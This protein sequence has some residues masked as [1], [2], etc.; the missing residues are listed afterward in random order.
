MF[1]V[2]HR[3]LT[4]FLCILDQRYNEVK[5]DGTAMARK[6]RKVGRTSSSR[7]PLGAPQ[8]AIDPQWKGDHICTTVG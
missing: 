4:Y 6:R 7:Q 2:A 5:E 8:R 1:L 3:G